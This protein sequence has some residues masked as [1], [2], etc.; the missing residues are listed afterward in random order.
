MMEFKDF[1]RQ[2]RAE[3]QIS[4]QELADRLS[5]RGQE[6]SYAR[7]SHWET[8]RNQPPI[9]LVA[10]RNALA[11][12]LE[13]TVDDL[14]R[15]LGYITSG[16]LSENAIQAA[17]IIERLPNDAQELALDLLHQLERRFA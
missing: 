2:R 12:S 9:E 15:T 16:N 14:M 17:Q 4:Q 5:E 1:L 3:L 10:F 6:T 8:G 7:V 13:M 11:L